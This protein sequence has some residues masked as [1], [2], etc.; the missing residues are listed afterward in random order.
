MKL[1]I[2]GHKL[3]ITPAI[4]S[5]ATK[6]IEKLDSYFDKISEAVL[7]LEVTRI[8]NNDI[9]HTAK[10]TLHLPNHVVVRGEE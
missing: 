9:S 6:K 7:E 5:Y 4:K 10:I 8:R 1:S 3:K 2:R